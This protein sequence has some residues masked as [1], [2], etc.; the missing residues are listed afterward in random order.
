LAQ[1]KEKLEPEQIEQLKMA[2]KK[3]I[4]YESVCLNEQCRLGKKLMEQDLD[5]HAH[6]VEIVN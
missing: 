3:E 5:R 6:I 1:L 2:L 4:E